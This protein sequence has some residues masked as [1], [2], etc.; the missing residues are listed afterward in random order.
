M[1]DSLNKHSVFWQF[2]WIYAT[3]Y[4]NIWINNAVFFYN[5]IWSIIDVYAH[6]RINI[7]FISSTCPFYKS[8][9]KI[10][11]CADETIT[12]EMRALN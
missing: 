8:T 11:K 9:W 7:I 4:C 3:K 2:K 6:V 10:V 1:T 5:S 12:K